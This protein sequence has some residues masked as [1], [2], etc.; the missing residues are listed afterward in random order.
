MLQFI[1]YAKKRPGANYI[2][3]NLFALTQAKT[4]KG[5]DQETWETMA[6]PGF[7]V[8]QAVILKG[9]YSS[10]R[11]LNPKCAGTL[12]DEVL[13][14]E[15]RQVCNVCS[16]CT[17]TAFT[18]T[19]LIGL[20]N[21][22]PYSH[23]PVKRFT[24]RTNAKRRFGPQLPPIAM[25]EQIGTFL[26]VK[27]LQPTE[28]IQNIEEAYRRLNEDPNH[29]MAN[30]YVGLEILLAS[31]ETFSQDQIDR[32]RNHL[33]IAV[34]SDSSIPESW[35]LLSR[36]CMRSADYIRAYQCLQTA[37][38]LKPRCPSFWITL[39][40]LYFR[41]GQSRDSLDALTKAVGLNAHIWEP[42]YNLGVLYDSCNGQHSDAADAFYKCLERKPDLSNVHARL[43]AQRSYA[44][45][46]C[47]ETLR[48]YL[49]H[50][51][52]D[53]SLEDKYGIIDEAG[54]ED[55]MFNPVYGAREQDQDDDKD[56]GEFEES[57]VSDSEQKYA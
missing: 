55:I 9:T 36:A 53:S 25:D 49:I 39:S 37:I 41:T 29:V 21:E 47:N 10:K 8:E 24:S 56:E 32:A 38:Y 6:K 4:G 40:I 42:W 22:A 45:D 35:Y 31:E 51:M 23:H 2:T 26:R 11:C 16:R 43:E 48:A 28:P 18:T 17:R 27:F 12:L 7:H 50:E 44:E 46:I 5:V 33:M 3:Q 13:E 54:G 30:A 20:Y 34:E 52:I 19:P 57:D 15:E 14:F 1:V